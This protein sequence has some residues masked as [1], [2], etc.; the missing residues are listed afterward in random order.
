MTI[1]GRMKDPGSLEAGYHQSFILDIIYHQLSVRHDQA[2]RL[3][4]QDTELLLLN[5]QEDCWELV[6]R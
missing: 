2:L 1:L 4:R 5:F 6:R 3:E